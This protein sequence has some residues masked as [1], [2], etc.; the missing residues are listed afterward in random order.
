MRTVSFKSVYDAILQR[1][2]LDPLGDAITADT[3]RA[4]TEHITQRASVAWMMWAW[5]QLAITEERAY[6]AP[7]YSTAQY[8]IGDQVYDLV[9][10]KYYTA[11]AAPPI[12]T[13]T[14]NAGYWALL[15][16]VTTTIARDQPGKPPI[17]KVLGVYSANPSLNGSAPR[18]ICLKFAPS[19]LGIFVSYAPLTTIFV[20]YIPPPPT[21]TMVPWIEVRPAYNPGDRVFYYPTGECYL[22][23]ASNNGHVPTDTLFWAQIPVPDI[24]ASYLKAGAASDCLRETFTSG[25]DQVRLARAAALDAEAD[26]FIQSEIDDLLA[27]GQ[28]NFYIKPYWSD[29]WCLSEPWLGSTVTVLSSGFSITAPDT[30]IGLPETPTIIYRA[31]IVALL[32]V[33]GTPSL[34]AFPSLSYPV[35]TLIKITIGTEEQSHRIDPGPKDVSDPN[36]TS[37]D[38]YNVV[39][40]NKHYQKVL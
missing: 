39:T 33:D 34:Q 35:G 17:G 38:D 24:F 25:E 16:P 26:S 10:Q 32:T 9:G 27:Q 18:D 14:S 15:Q 3:A 40:N 7:W 2:G 30:P 20:C 28:K 6:R 11:T 5:P 31:E 8:K 21:Y 36:Q 29:G 12:G 19:A 37:P 4:I 1:L 23:L 22:C 13:P